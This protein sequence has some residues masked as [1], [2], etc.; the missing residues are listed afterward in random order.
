MRRLVCAVVVVV[1]AELQA[2]RL[3]PARLEEVLQRAGERVEQYFRR[4]QSIVCREVVNIQPLTALWAND[5]MSRTVESEL[6][7]SWEPAADG[8]PSPE[9]Q[10][11]RRLLKVNG[12]PPRKDDWNNCT[13][14]E[15]QAQEPQ[16]LS[17]LLPSLRAEYQFALAGRTLLDRRA[18]ILIDYRMRREPSVETRMVEGRDDCISFNLEGGTRGRIWIDEETHHVLR[19]DQSLS[20]LVEIPLPREA[21]RRGDGPASW[22]MERWDVSIR[23]RQVA[24]ENPAETLVLPESLSS[25]RITRGSGAPRL[26]T[27]TEYL[28]YQRFLTS[29]KIVGN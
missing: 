17:L 1:A 29:G 28:N 22:T 4:A 13:A 25:L 3:E 18:A 26:R 9:A 6:R 23:F 7:L 19:L 8:T 10:M 5:G 20:G 24:F 12:G 27:K 2:A 21:T 15:Q 14:P 11:L 16:A